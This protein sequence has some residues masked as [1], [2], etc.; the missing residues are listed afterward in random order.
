MPT[1]VWFQVRQKIAK[2]LLE[3]AIETVINLD[4]LSRL[5]KATKL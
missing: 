4:K 2:T 5:K 1:K 3:L